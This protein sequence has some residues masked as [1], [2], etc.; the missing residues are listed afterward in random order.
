VQQLQT[1]GIGTAT[2][3]EI[4]TQIVRESFLA[5]DVA[6]L[7]Q[8]KGSS[9]ACGTVVAI[10]SVGELVVGNVGDTRALLATTDGESLLL[11]NVHKPEDSEERER[12]TGCGAFVV[13]NRVM[14]ILAV[15]RAF[16]DREFK[17]TKEELS[18]PQLTSETSG[19]SYC[20]DPTVPVIVSGVPDVQ[21]RQVTDKDKFIIVCSDGVVDS[22]T[23]EEALD[24]VYGQLDELAQPDESDL[25]TIAKALA[26]Q[27]AIVRPS[28]DDITAVIALIRSAPSA[29]ETDTA[30]P[31]SPSSSTAHA[32]DTPTIATVATAPSTVATAPTAAAGASDGETEVRGSPEGDVTSLDRVEPRLSPHAQ[33]PSPPDIDGW[34]LPR[35]HGALNVQIVQARDLKDKVMFGAM[36]PMVVAHFAEQSRQTKIAKHAGRNCEW[37][38]VAFRCDGN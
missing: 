3:S 7:K 1:K 36:S 23:H 38:Q 22:F 25:C 17:I 34:S 14:G 6:A 15:S 29:G 16:G 10:N 33:P 19:R 30:V 8:I 11:H 24:L 27:A 28:H 32:V 2:G 26:E 12:I 5:S 9:G 35:Q 13:K 18:D 20:S 37:R 21:T 31:E 4:R